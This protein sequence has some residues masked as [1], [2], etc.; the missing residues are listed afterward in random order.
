MLDMIELLGV[1]PE[2]YKELGLNPTDTY[3]A[4]AK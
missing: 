2:K 3:F 1:I 4:M